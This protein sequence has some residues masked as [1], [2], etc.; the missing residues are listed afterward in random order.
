MESCSSFSWA[1][2]NLCCVH[3]GLWVNNYNGI[4]KY[5]S[6]SLA[7][8]IDIDTETFVMLSMLVD[9]SSV[10]LYES[11]RHVVTIT[12]VGDVSCTDV[13]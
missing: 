4:V 1:R 12:F 2:S 9:L 13:W 10:T 5:K 8:S 3:T 7:L 6:A 11:D